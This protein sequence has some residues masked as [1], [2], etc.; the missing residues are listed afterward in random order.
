MLPDGVCA[1]CL[2]REVLL[3]PMP[4]VLRNFTF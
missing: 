3:Q 1:A 2:M 4:D